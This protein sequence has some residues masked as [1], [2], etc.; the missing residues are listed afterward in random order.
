MSQPDVTDAGAV[1]DAL[2]AAL[3]ALVQA[4]PDGS[5]SQLAGASEHALELALLTAASSPV[6]AALL[7]AAS[8]PAGSALVDLCCAMERCLELIGEGRVDPGLALPAL[9]M[10][11][12]T[13]RSSFAPAI[14]AARYEIETLLPIPGQAPAPRRSLDVPAQSLVRRP[15]LARAD[16][17]L[18]DPAESGA[19]L[20][21]DPSA[22]PTRAAPP[23]GAALAAFPTA[24]IRPQRLEQIFAAWPESARLAV[25]SARQRLRPT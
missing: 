8:S 12:H 20:R 7:T 19:A 25:A 16:L 6:G 21:A 2:D 5:P 14:S 18:G 9:A 4:A 3:L 22:S 11:A 23:A 13:A 1:L 17:G 15:I 10:A 24:A